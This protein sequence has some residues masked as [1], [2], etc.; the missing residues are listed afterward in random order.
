M[1]FIGQRFLVGEYPAPVVGMA[2]DLCVPSRLIQQV[3]QTLLHARLVVEAS[4]IDV[5]YV[6]ARPLDQISVHDV[7][8]A[9]RSAHGQQL[10]IVDEPVRNEVY[11]E[12]TRI[13]EAERAAASSVTI[14]S[15]AH[16]ARAKQLTPGNAPVNP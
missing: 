11:G 8:M 6:P 2:Q 10:S 16:R 4:G 9:M 3:M 15:L 12:F 1:T 7:L 13:E 5:S 14:L